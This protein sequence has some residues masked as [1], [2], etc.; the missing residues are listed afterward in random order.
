MDFEQTKKWI[1]D[2]QVEVDGIIDELKNDMKSD[3]SL[4]QDRGMQIMLAMLV[5]RSETLKQLDAHI[6][7]EK[8]GDN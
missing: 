4:A 7:G 2:Q 5:S 6:K 3:S 8:Y 1:A